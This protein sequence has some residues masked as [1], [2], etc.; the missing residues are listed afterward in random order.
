MGVT[1]VA[2]QRGL[3]GAQVIGVLGRGAGLPGGC[4]GAKMQGAGCRDAGCSG[5]ESTW[6]PR[7]LLKEVTTPWNHRLSPS[8]LVRVRVRARVRVS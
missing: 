3:G 5:G 1:G 6:C 4:R 7:T 2:G 8:H